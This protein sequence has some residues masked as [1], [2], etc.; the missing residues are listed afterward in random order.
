MSTMLKVVFENRRRGYVRH[1]QPRRRRHQRDG[2]SPLTAG[3]EAV[4]FSDRPGDPRIVAL[5]ARTIGH[6]DPSQ[7][8]AAVSAVQAE[9]PRWRSHPG[10]ASLLSRRHVWIPDAVDSR[11]PITVEAGDDDVVAALVERLRLAVAPIS[12]GFAVGL[13]QQEASDVVIL[14][15]HHALTDG[16]GALALMSRLVAAGDDDIVKRSVVGR[17]PQVNAVNGTGSAAGP[18]IGRVRPS[19]PWHLMAPSRL[20]RHV[21]PD[22]VS[23]FGFVNTSLTI[24]KVAP[25][26]TFNDVL[27]SSTIRA[28]ERWN[29]LHQGTVGRITVYMPIYRPAAASPLLEI[30]NA[31]GQAIVYTR[32]EDRRRGAL[33]STVTAQTQ[34]AKAMQHG[35]AGPVEQAVTAL[36]WM[37]AVLRRLLLRQLARVVVRWAMPTTTV[38]NL[39]RVDG[40]FPSAAASEPPAAVSVRSLVFLT[41]AGVPQGV[42]VTAAGLGGRL[43]LSVS[44]AKAMLSDVAAR[45]FLAMI[46][47]GVSD[48][49]QPIPDDAKEY[50]SS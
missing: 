19:R 26:A 23:G 31:T 48:L 46:A 13:V 18:R 30:G 2:W 45:S 40:F 49:A 47:E 5:L 7:L 27:I 29:G 42:T 15:V 36:L 3:E 34:S 38:S 22:S 33:L 14:V 4:W 9:R 41:T 8:G 37:P 32:P 24:G 16:M 28:V 21:T 20:A 50:S 11:H 39:G 1:V 43:Q 44:Y 17:P 12:P 35:H 6:L 25:P 10:K